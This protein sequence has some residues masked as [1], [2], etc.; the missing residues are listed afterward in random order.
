MV[1]RDRAPDTPHPA[2]GIAPVRR[3]GVGQRAQARSIRP[4][5]LDGFGRQIDYLRVSVTDHCN[6]RCIYCMPLEGLRHAPASEQLS[7]G[8]IERVVRAAAGVGFTKVRFTGGEPTLRGDIVDI[9]GRVARTPGIRHVAMTT[10]GVLLPRLAAP[11]AEAGLKRVNI[12]I[13][14]LDPVRL[15]KVMRWGSVDAIWKGIEAAEAAGLSP[16]KLNCVVVAEHND[17]DVVDLA[18]LTVD[19]DWHVRFIELM[20]FGEGECAIVSWERYVSNRDTKARIEDALGA[21]TA[22]PPSHAA[23]ESKNYRLPDAKGVVGFISPVSEPYCGSCNRMRLTADGKFHLCLLNDDE[24]DVKRL[25][26][27]GGS[28]AEIAETLL[29]AVARKPTGHH[30]ERG[31]TTELRIMYQIGG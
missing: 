7:A 9:V 21:L 29:Q 22:L 18:R 2:P 5:P 19:R 1:L 20:P 31:K 11:L 27:G 25:L 16:I 30:L 13:D 28:D 26:R 3:A 10:N 4:M 24:L 15:A 23:E 14:S 12:H 6:L 17:L 8:E